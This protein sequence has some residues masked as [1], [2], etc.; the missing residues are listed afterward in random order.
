M[1]LGVPVVAQRKGI[2]LVST[3]MRVGSLAL[4]SELRIWRCRELWCSLQTWLSL[5]LLLHRPAA[6]ALIRFLAQEL[7]YAAGVALENKN[8]PSKQKKNW[9]KQSALLTGLFKG[10]R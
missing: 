7:P 2:R 6:A 1:D 4:I 8:Q 9:S 3:R 10:L 5:V